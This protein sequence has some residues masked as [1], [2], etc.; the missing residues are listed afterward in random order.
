MMG[1]PATASSLQTQQPQQSPA[2]DIPAMTMVTECANNENIPTCN[3]SYDST[4]VTY[5]SLIQQYLMMF[6]VDN[7]IW[8]AERCIAEYSHCL[9]A[10]YLLAL[11]Y[12]RKGKIKNAWHILERK[13]STT[14]V[15]P[16]SCSKTLASI[17]YLSA[18]CSYELGEYSLGEI[19][20][21]KGTRKA[22][23]AA[24]TTEGMD[25]WILRTSVSEFVISAASFSYLRRQ[26]ET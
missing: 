8:L 1:A 11:A 5:L 14:F 25:D 4:C 26:D 7:A 22:Y 21:L 23:K 13:T 24:N 16:A 17:H 18:Q 20:L 9:D 3:D 6:Q 2:N 12:Y 15:D 19:A 10:V